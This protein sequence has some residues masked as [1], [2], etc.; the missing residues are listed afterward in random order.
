MRIQVHALNSVYQWEIE[1]HTCTHARVR[2]HTHTHTHT[3][4]H[5]YTHIRTSYN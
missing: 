4:K 2:T 5:I 3:H 1:H